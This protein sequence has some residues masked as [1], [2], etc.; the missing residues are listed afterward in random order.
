[1]Y[2]RFLPTLGRDFVL[3]VRDALFV[4][5]ALAGVLAILAV[6][7]MALSRA[8]NRQ[9]LERAVAILLVMAGM[10]CL[11]ALWVYISRST[12]GL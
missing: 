8:R 7:R 11:A 2:R 9:A 6:A 5:L 4:L 1:M 3:L 12:P 10:A